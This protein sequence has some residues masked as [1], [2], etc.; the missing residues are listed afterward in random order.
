MRIESGEVSDLADAGSTSRTILIRIVFAVN[1]SITN[2]VLRP[3]VLVSRY[4]LTLEIRRR[5]TDPRCCRPQT[6]AREA[7]DRRA[8]LTP[9]TRSP[10]FNRNHLD[11]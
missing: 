3:A 10:N 4:S 11:L 1:D 5:R 6:L 9:A 7:L 2:V 8:E